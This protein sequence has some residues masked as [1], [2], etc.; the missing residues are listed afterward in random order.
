MG[1]SQKPWLYDSAAILPNYIDVGMWAD[2]T[3]QSSGN[4]TI[5]LTLNYYSVLIFQSLY[6]YN[7]LPSLS[8]IKNT[9][10]YSVMFG[11]YIQV[12]LH[13]AALFS[14]EKLLRSCVKNLIFLKIYVHLALAAF[15]D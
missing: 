1:Y 7:K 4:I 5:V 13:L 10:L 11:V 3:D 8:C 12:I 6:F 2:K 9:V 15:S 14:I